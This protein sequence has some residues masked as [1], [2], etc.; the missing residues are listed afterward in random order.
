MPESVK[1]PECGSEISGEI[2]SNLC[3]QCLLRIGLGGAQSESRKTNI[4]SGKE[5]IVKKTDP[6]PTAAKKKAD[7]GY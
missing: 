3:L 4:D 7:L 2:G 6:L 5:A 1:C